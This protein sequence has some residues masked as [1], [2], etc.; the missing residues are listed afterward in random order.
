MIFEKRL[1]DSKGESVL[2]YDQIELLRKNNRG[3]YIIAQRGSQEKF[4][5]SQADITI[6]GGSRGGAKSFSLLMEGLKDITNPRF[7]AILMRNEKTDLDDLVK[8]SYQL[9]TQF[10]TYNRSIND[11]TWNFLNGGSL[12]FSYY[13]GTYS[14]FETRFRGRQFSFIGI[15]E[16]TQIEFKKFKFLVTCNR[17]AAKIRNRFYGTCNPDPDSWVR[18]FIDWWIGEDGL[19]IKE[20]DGVKRYCFMDGDTP[21]T[22]YWGDSPE[23]VYE[24][25]ANIIDKLWKPEY[26]DLGFDKVTMFIKSVTFIFGKL[27]ENVALITSDP[28]YVANLAQQGDEQRARD[29]EG[30]WN[31]KVAGDDIIKMDEMEH[32][33]NNPIQ[34]KDQ[35]RY[36]SCDIALEN[37]DICVLWLW[38]GDH[39]EDICVINGDSKNLVETVTL[40]MQ[41]WGVLEKDMVYDVNGIGQYFKGFFKQAELFGNGAAPI[42]PTSAEERT[43]K[44]QYAN[45]KSQCAAMFANKLKNGELSINPELLN[46]KF[47]CKAT[48]SHSVIRFEQK[49]L[50]QILMNERKAIRDKGTDKGFAIISKDQM[51]RYVG[52]SP[53]Y[54][55]SLIYKQKFNIKKSHK[56]KGTWML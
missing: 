36:I 11:M 5:S 9:Y 6:V 48:R 45:L 20:R 41:E 44:L 31:F 28:N 29:L 26:A 13:A 38:I 55:E 54:I 2:T 27:E 10:G 3:Q 51:I 37:G 40:K 1:T 16:I 25:C 18:I 7:N 42:A 50:R 32:F 34:H 14:D 43:I 19:P 17:N 47:P 15:D 4:L 52:H 33:F 35:H 23:E 24:Q 30:N 21:D 22:I 12:K 49:P 53:D 56:P 8:T 46:K 39:I